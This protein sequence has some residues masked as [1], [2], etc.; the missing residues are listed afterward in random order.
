[1]QIDG[2]LQK[3]DVMIESLRNIK[4]SVPQ[5]HWN[6]LPWRHRRFLYRQSLGKHEEKEKD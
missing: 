6:Q 1:M 3:A 5:A 2:I 4:E